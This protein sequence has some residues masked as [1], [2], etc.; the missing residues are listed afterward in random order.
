YDESMKEKFPKKPSTN[1]AED[2]MK[3]CK[4]L[5]K[6]IEEQSS[7][8]KIPSIKERIN[9]LKEVIE[10]YHEQQ[11]YSEDPDACT[12]H[13]SVDY[14]FHG[15]KTH[16]AMSDERIITAALITSGEKG[17]GQYLEELVENSVDNGMEIDTVVGDT[18]YSG[19]DNLNYAKDNF[20][21]ISK[22]HPIITNGTRKKEDEFS[23]NKDAGL[24]VCPAGHLAKRKSIKKKKDRNDQ[25]RYHFDVNICKT[26]PLRD[27]CYKEGAKSKTYCVTIKSTE[28][29]EHEAFQN[30]DEFKELAK[31]RY[32]IEAKNSELKNRHGFKQAKSSGLFGMQIQGATTIFAVNMKRIIKLM[33]EK[34]GKKG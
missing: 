28:H 6:T 32:K 24:F 7:L 26:C 34:E 23:F 10:D 5:L 30:T 29:T 12:G 2:E 19:T 3:Y 8:T 31:N 18:A 1:E 9:V 16:I 22:L 13:K 11:L 27:G 14:S 20:N 21:L 4:K 15:Y 33:N 17:D 25:M